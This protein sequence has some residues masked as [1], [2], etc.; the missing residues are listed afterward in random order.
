MGTSTVMKP[1]PQFVQLPGEIQDMV[2]DEAAMISPMVHFMVP[3]TSV[4]H[5]FEGEVTLVPDRQSGALGLVHLSL[6]CRGARAAVIRRNKKIVNK[7]IF[8][9][10]HF[11]G[12]K[13]INLAL[14]LRADLVCLTSPTE[15]PDWEHFLL[16]GARRV[17]I[18]FDPG[19]DVDNGVLSQQQN[20]S[21]VGGGCVHTSLTQS[22]VN[23][24]SREVGSSPPGPLFCVRCIAEGLR[25]FRNLEEFYLI[26]GGED[27]SEAM[28]TKE[29]DSERVRSD[30]RAKF[31]SYRGTCFE[32]AGLDT[33]APWTKAQ[34]RPAMALEGIRE[35]L[36]SH[37][38]DEKPI[39]C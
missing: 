38:F 3:M 11:H 7:S 1:F 8:R 34:M 12:Y 19:W 16:W 37:R 5:W 10:F 14:N 6:A 18:R 17:A 4:S 9:T 39:V 27:K 20:L 15:W 24:P 13:T 31:F 21:V 29:R 32:V 25:R 30:G 33:I 26:L 22:V 28:L 2:W 35:C 36:V 23:N